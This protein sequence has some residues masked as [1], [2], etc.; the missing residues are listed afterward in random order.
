M[1]SHSASIVVVATLLWYYTSSSNSVCSQQI[2][3][4]DCVKHNQGTSLREGYPGGECLEQT[5]IVGT[6]LVLSCL[7]LFFGSIVAICFRQRFPQS[8]EM[9]SFW[10]PGAL[11]AVGT[12]FTNLG[13]AL[14]GASLVQ[15][16][17]LLEPIET[18]IL[19]TA[20]KFFSTG[21]LDLSLDMLLSVLMIVAGTFFLLGGR[22]QGDAF[23]W[24]SAYCALASG[25]CMT[26][27]NVTLKN[28]PTTSLPKRRHIELDQFWLG[29]KTFERLSM[30]GAVVSCFSAIL[31]FFAGGKASYTQFTPRLFVQAVSFFSAYQI[32]SIVVLSFTSAQT[33]SLLNVGKRI[34]NVF[35][36][37]YVFSEE[38][39]V[40]GRLGLVLA[41]VGGVL[42]SRRRKVISSKVLAVIIIC[43]LV[44][45]TGRVNKS[46]DRDL[47]FHP[48]PS[49][50][51]INH[52]FNNISES[53]GPTFLLRNT[54]L[55]LCEP[56]KFQ[57]VCTTHMRT[58]EFDKINA[59]PIF[60]EYFTDPNG[61][62]WL[63]QKPVPERP[64]STD[65]F[66]PDPVKYCGSRNAT[67]ANLGDELGA[68]LLSKLSGNKVIE[69]RFDGMDVVVIG[70]V[71]NFMVSN[72][73]VSTSRIKMSYN[74]TVW[75]AGTKW[76]VAG[77]CFDFR[78]VRGPKTREAFS[79]LGCS[80]PD[81]YGDPALLMPYLYNPRV[82]QDIDLCIIPHMDD[83]LAGR[84]GWWTANGFESLQSR[85]DFID[86]KMVGR[87]LRVIDI[88]TPDAG[89]FIDFIKSCKNIASGSLHGIILAEA[90]G[91]NW[92][93]IRLTEKMFEKDFKYHD[94]FL[95]VGVDP[96]SVRVRVD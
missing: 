79:K 26:I 73:K 7:E 93:W 76:G 29:V 88:R 85:F 53:T 69:K 83:L 14:G 16:I 63:K 45:N 27:R 55:T 58:R 62:K 18:L 40:Q 30:S 20:A 22:I 24:H 82:S 78:A 67:C 72:Y 31:F 21:V 39:T 54:P 15:M 57:M 46:Y 23:P 19:M 91:I 5:S 61:T 70:S 17:K 66:R 36:A 8:S 86:H 44:G 90:Y 43:L 94:F 50:V 84:F 96:S 59:R 74:T 28:R 56:Q 42:Y 2:L 6:S 37:A 25:A 1:F 75:G 51:A 12:F 34:F 48:L 92:S 80:I 38:I 11:H 81:V 35:V 3:Y 77:T 10:A 71:L 65:W 41:A 68:L 49:L 32:S 95:S 33:H 89:E 47:A 64:I 52:G 60:A 87:T 9:E 13:F 4:T